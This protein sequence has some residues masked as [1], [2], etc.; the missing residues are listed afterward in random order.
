[1]NLQGDLGDVSLTSLIQLLCT[2]GKSGAIV[3]ERK[4]PIEGGARER[5]L[6]YLAGGEIVEAAAGSAR[7]EKALYRLLSWDEAAFKIDPSLRPPG[8]SIW[9]SW[10]AI[11][12]DGMR[13]LD[14]GQHED[15]IED[16]FVALMSALE[17]IVV[18]LRKETGRHPGRLLQ[19]CGQLVNGAAEF[20]DQLPEIDGGKRHLAQV[21]AG[22]AR[23]TPPAQLVPIEGNRLS[24]GRLEALAGHLEEGPGNPDSLAVAEALLDVLDRCLQMIVNRF[25]S[26]ELREDWSETCRHFVAEARSSV[27][28]VRA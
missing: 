13:H 24:L 4:T 15:R 27:P 16:D 23:E 7:G 17:Q 11:L 9:A 21:L 28:A 20:W 18:S 25:P 6:L 8:R 26:A 10:N 2:R 22:V 3:L 12:L 14:E 5:G 1:M 19:R